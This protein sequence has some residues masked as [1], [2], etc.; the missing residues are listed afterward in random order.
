VQ[1]KFVI[2]GHTDVSGSYDYNL[3]LSSAGA[4]AVKVHLVS[5]RRRAGTLKAVGRG[6]DELL[7]EDNPRSPAN[8]RV[9]PAVAD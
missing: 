6:P 8:R 5:A 2:S 3:R 4:D 1:A 7:D 9:Q